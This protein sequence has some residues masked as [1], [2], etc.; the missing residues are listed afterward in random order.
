MKNKTNTTEAQI[1]DI[2]RVI[3]LS[4]ARTGRLNRTL[5][6]DLCKIVSEELEVHKVPKRPI[7]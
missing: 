7:I 4:F 1:L 2:I 5:L 3:L 6:L